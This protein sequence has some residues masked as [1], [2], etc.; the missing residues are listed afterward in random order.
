M[1]VR[2]LMLLLMR[3]R[4]VP[5]DVKV[6]RRLWELYLDP[7][8]VGSYEHL[9]TETG[10]TDAGR[11]RGGGGGGGGGG[12][13]RCEGVRVGHGGCGNAHFRAWRLSHIDGD[14]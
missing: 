8:Q 2:L 5:V 3:L 10:S 6:S 7:F 4:Y 14:L 11:C 1:L 13:L 12:G 9:A